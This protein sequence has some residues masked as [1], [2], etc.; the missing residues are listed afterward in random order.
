LSELAVAGIGS[1]LLVEII[2][3]NVHSYGKLRLAIDW[4]NAIMADAALIIPNS[5]GTAF[6]SFGVANCFAQFVF[7][8]RQLFDL[9]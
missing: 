7:G 8:F 4:M 1:P 3:S 5:M 9:K 2:L 6:V